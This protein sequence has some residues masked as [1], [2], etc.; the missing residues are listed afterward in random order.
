MTAPWTCPACKAAVE[1]VTFAAIA[2]GY[3]FAIF[4]LT[5]TTT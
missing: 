3:R 5:L 4:A 2:L 1:A